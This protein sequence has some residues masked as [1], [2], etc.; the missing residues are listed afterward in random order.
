YSFF[1][2]TATVGLTVWIFFSM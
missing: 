1:V 2:A